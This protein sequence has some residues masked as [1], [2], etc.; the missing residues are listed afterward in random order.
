MSTITVTVGV[1]GSGK[2]TWAKAQNQPIVSR[3]D[4]REELTGAVGKR[5]LTEDGERKV[6]KVQRERVKE[7]LR[8]GEDVIV[9][10]TNLSYKAQKQWV[11]LAI[12]MGAGIKFEVFEVPLDV[13]LERNDKREPHDRVPEHVIRSMFDRNFSEDGTLKR[14]LPSHE[15][16]VAHEFV[17]YVPGTR[18]AISVDLDGTLAHNVTSRPWFEPSRYGEDAVDKSIKELIALYRDAGHEVII[19]TA[20]EGTNRGILNT[21]LWLDKH[22]IKFDEI[23]FRQEGDQRDDGVVKSEIIDKQISHKYDIKFHLDDRDRVVQALRRK[24]YP[25]W[26]V[27][28]GNY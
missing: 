11:D 25:V 8:A 18:E 9:A 23:F 3:D 1:P 17:P 16:A 20:R 15:G 10:D 21:A 5:V 27:T 12:Q 7:L 6:T 13:A 24:N 19:L 2:T 28:N 4:I 22:G 14:D 26:Q